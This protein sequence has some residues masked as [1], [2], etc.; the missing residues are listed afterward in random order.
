MP[1]TLPDPSVLDP[2]GIAAVQRLL[3][4][5]QGPFVPK[6]QLPVID[7]LVAT[8][9]SQHTSDLNSG[10][11]FAQLKAKFVGSSRVDLQACKLEYSI[12]S[13]K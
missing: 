8:V 10:R 7:E 5:S 11:A 6:P 9:L 1:R 3:R 13:P 2:S 12:V 4:A